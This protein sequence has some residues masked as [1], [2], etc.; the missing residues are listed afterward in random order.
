MDNPLWGKLLK[1][2]KKQLGSVKCLDFSNKKDKLKQIKGIF[3]QNRMNDVV[4]AKLKKSLICKI[5]LKQMSY[6][7]NQNVE[8]FIILMHVFLVLQR[9]T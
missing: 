9:C 1:T 7:I 8:K 2:T 6:I 4:G 3:P 5:L